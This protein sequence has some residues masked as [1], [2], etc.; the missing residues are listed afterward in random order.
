[1]TRVPVTWGIETN[2]GLP[3]RRDLVSLDL[4]RALRARSQ[5][6]SRGDARPRGLGPGTAFPDE[7]P[8][9]HR[10][11]PLHVDRPARLALEVVADELVRR[12]AEVDPPRHAVRLHAARGVHGVAPDVEN[13]LSQSDDPA[14]AGPAV[15]ADPEVDAVLTCRAE[16][17]D[18]RAHVEGQARYRLRVIRTAAWNPRDTHEVVA[19]GADLLHA[20]PLREEVKAGEDPV[21]ERDKLLGVQPLREHR[22]SDDVR[23]EHGRVFVGVGDRALTGLEPRRD[24][25]GQHVQKEA[26]RAF[27]LAGECVHGAVA[28]GEESRDQ[29]EDDRAPN[30]DVET[31]HRACE[32]LR[33]R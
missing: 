1:M 21:E 22:G 26:L 12:F 31:E 17:V 32:P 8:R 16:L 13:E 30:G 14:H 3:S 10:A 9:A 24:L 25:P 29:S 4:C 33:D 23:E 18:A 11:L 2:Y 5:S 27:L 6:T 28:L 15:Y 19:D 7:E 20:V